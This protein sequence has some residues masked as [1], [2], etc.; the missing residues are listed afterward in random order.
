MRTEHH[1]EFNRRAI[2]YLSCAIFPA[3]KIGDNDMTN[4]TTS[5]APAEQTLRQAVDEST[6]AAIDRGTLDAKANAAPI[7]LLRRMADVLDGSTDPLTM[8]YCT[9]ASFTALFDKLGLL[10]TE[11]QLERTAPKRD[12]GASVV[13]KSKW[14]A[15][16][17]SG[18]PRRTD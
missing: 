7:A 12:S 18:Y 11:S 5:K 16:M 10:P 13:G 6:T 8:R 15:R 1:A 3:W 4:K 9:P 2:F 17:Q 14:A